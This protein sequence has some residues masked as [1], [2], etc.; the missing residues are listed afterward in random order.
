MLF[1][2]GIIESNG[3]VKRTIA[4]ESGNE[5]TGFFKKHDARGKGG[6]QIERTPTHEYT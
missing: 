1:V 6:I 2:S 5:H 4:M 3:Y